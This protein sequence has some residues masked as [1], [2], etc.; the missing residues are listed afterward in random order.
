M[1]PTS[2]LEG[3]TQHLSEQHHWLTAHWP[4]LVTCPT[5]PPGR[6]RQPA[7]PGSGELQPF[8]EGLRLHEGFPPASRCQNLGLQV[9]HQQNRLILP[10]SRKRSSAAGLEAGCIL[11]PFL[12]AWRVSNKSLNLPGP[13]F[14]VCNKGFV[15]PPS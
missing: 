3:L 13:C 15:A 14:L 10:G 6:K 4:A 5:R 9:C 1:L 2:V 11:V 8:R 12:G 7:T